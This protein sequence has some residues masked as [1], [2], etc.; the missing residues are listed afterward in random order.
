MTGNPVPDGPSQHAQAALEALTRVS[1]RYAV[2]MQRL[3]PAENSTETLNELAMILQAMLDHAKI[4]IQPPIPIPPNPIPD[5]SG[6]FSIPMPPEA[7]RRLQAVRLDSLSLPGHGYLNEALGIYT[8]ADL[9]LYSAED[10]V[11]VKGLT[12][13]IVRAIELILGQWNLW[14]PT[15]DMLH[16]EAAEF[17]VPIKTPKQAHC[18]VA[19]HAVPEL[20]LKPQPDPAKRQISLYAYRHRVIAY[21]GVSTVG[22]LLALSTQERVELLRAAARRIT[23][24]ALQDE[25]IAPEDQDSTVSATLRALTDQLNQFMHDTGLTTAG[26]KLR[27][28]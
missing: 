5:W 4:T 22:D 12:R 18:R 17:W 10:L 6:P 8:L 16:H 2:L 28:D 15:W 3:L 14:L 11:R 19:R 13:E 21:L 25:R 27:K 9:M 1:R 26:F 20:S 23:D 7:W 24:I